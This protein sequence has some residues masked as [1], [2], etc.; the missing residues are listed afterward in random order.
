VRGHLRFDQFDEPVE[1]NARVVEY[2]GG[3][4]YSWHGDLATYEHQRAVLTLDDGR[5]VAVLVDGGLLRRT[6][7]GPI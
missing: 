3:E 2:G 7:A 5:M 4:A 6:E 1:R